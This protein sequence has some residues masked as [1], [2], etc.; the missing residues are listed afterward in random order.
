[1]RS[2]RQANTIAVRL[3]AVLV[4]CVACLPG[5]A[6]PRVNATTLDAEGRFYSETGF[7]LAPEFVQFFDLYG[8]LALF[9]YPITEARREGGYLVQWTERQRLEWHPENLGTPHEVLL[10]LLGRELTRGYNGPRFQ[11]QELTLSTQEPSSPTYYFRE[12]GQTVAEPFLSYWRAHGGL[13]VFGYPISTLHTNE[14][15]LQV[16]WFERARFEYHPENPAEHHVLLGHLGYAALK[17][18]EALAYELEVYGTPAPDGDMKIDL[19]QGGESEDSGFFDNVQSLGRELGPGLVRLDNIFNHYQIVSRGS[20]GAL[21]YNWQSLD[22]ILDGV[23]A[24]GKE[25]LICLSYMPETMS[26]HGD[27]RVMPPASYDEWAALVKATVTHVNVARGLK[28]RYWEVWNEPDQA[29]FWK[30]SFQE[31]LKLYD[32]TVE[33]ATSADPSIRIGGPA[34]ARFSPDHLDEFMQHEAMQGSKGRVDFISWHSYGQSPDQVAA[35]IREL[36]TILEKY[37]QFTPE[38]FITEFNVLQGGPGDTSANSATDK[39]EG[40]IAFL[41]SIEGMQRERLDRAFLFEL[42]D[43]L[44]PKSYWGRWGIL[45]NDAQPKPTYYALKAYQDRPPGM[46]PII[47]KRGPS[48]RSLGMMAYGGPSRA[49]LFLWYTGYE[50]ARIKVGLPASFASVQFDLTLFDAN[51]NNPAKT[52]DSTLKTWLT[53]DAGDLVLDLKPNSLVILTTR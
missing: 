50:E 40:A 34:V 25:P 47:T 9:G 22:R 15:G 52:G 10:G 18:R 16:Q 31:Y 39:V 35:H 45:T 7:T 27:S 53:R 17:E 8:G 29:G 49:T 38:L 42:K 11:Q 2:R 24:M 14:N 30:A 4:F 46:L 33:A 51:H 20:D 37:P 19:A 21:T 5:P 13:P 32:V 36:R 26:A 43:G 3:I 44:G 23:R 1:M 12:T 6:S 28:V 41:T 48:D